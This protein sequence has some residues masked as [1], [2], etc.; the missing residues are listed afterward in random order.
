[1]YRILFKK[2]GSNNWECI[3]SYTDIMLAIEEL[4]RLESGILGSSGSFMI[5]REGSKDEN[6]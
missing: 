2:N 3:G 1:M 4:D 6:I 5:K